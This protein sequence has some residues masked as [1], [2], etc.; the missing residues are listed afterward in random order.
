MLCAALFPGFCLFKLLDSRLRMFTSCVCEAEGSFGNSCFPSPQHRKLF[1]GIMSSCSAREGQLGETFHIR[2]RNLRRSWQSF[3]VGFT[4]G[5]AR[6]SV[7]PGEARGKGKRADKGRARAVW[8]WPQ[9]GVRNSQDDAQGRAA[10]K[11][12]TQLLG[13]AE[14]HW[15]TSRTRA[16]TQVHHLL[17]RCQPS[18][19]AGGTK[20]CGAPA[21]GP[22]CAG[23]RGAEAL[24]GR[25]TCMALRPRDAWHPR[26][27]WQESQQSFGR[28]MCWAW[29]EFPKVTFVTLGVARFSLT[30]VSSWPC[31]ATASERVVVCKQGGTGLPLRLSHTRH[32]QAH[33]WN[34][35]SPK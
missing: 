8:A 18:G 11:A 30:S 34:S 6:A 1:C 15:V 28:Y 7:H 26:E 10:R 3:T 14:R 19:K 13:A 23:P 33:L 31:G 12:M 5:W 25:S 21:E 35:N 9:R 2:S 20:P 17:S 32:G 29:F 4:P 24:L 16:S 27:L 22:P